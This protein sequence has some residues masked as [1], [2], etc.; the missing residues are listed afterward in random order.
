VIVPALPHIVPFKSWNKCR[1]CG[2]SSVWSKTGRGK[3]T[4]IEARPF[5]P[6][7]P[8][9]KELPKETKDEILEVVRRFF[10]AKF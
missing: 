2:H 4:V 1:V 10:E 9:I 7:E 5:I 3:K 6:I 8:D